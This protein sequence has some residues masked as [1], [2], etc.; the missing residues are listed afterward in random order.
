MIL[1]LLA[2]MAAPAFASDFAPTPSYD[3]LQT[4]LA[5]TVP[6]QFPS[7]APEGGAVWCPTNTPAFRRSLSPKADAAITSAL[8]ALLL[9]D[10]LPELRGRVGKDGVS[11]SYAAALEARIKDPAV[12]LWKATENKRGL[13]MV[14][15]SGALR[16]VTIPLS[17]SALFPPGAE[18]DLMKRHNGLVCEPEFIAWFDAA[19][20]FLRM[21]AYLGACHD[22]N[23]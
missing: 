9:G 4:V 10:V 12:D 1:S 13:V 11:L 18:A 14:D 21:N 5:Q 6:G 3:D 8:K 16:G 19:G 23:E 17:L 2:L 15:Y 20:N 7:C 22:G